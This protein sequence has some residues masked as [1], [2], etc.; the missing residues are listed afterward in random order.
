MSASIPSNINI[1]GNFSSAGFEGLGNF[2]GGLQGQEMPKWLTDHLGKYGLSIGEDGMVKFDSSVTKN[3]LGEA[4]STLLDDLSAKFADDGKGG[5]FDL[6]ELLNSGDFSKMLEAYQAG[7]WASLGGSGFSFGNS[8]LPGE[9]QNLSVPTEATGRPEGDTRSA[10]EIIAANPA[11]ANLGDQ[12]DIKRDQLK[13]RFG[14]WTA[15]NPDPEARAD[16]AYNAA[17][18]LNWIDSSNNREGGY[19]GPGDG[20][21]QGITS[22]GDARHGT[23]AGNLKDFAE[24]GYGA[25]K[26]DHRLDQTN[27]KHVRLDGSN[28]DN[29]EKFMD[30]VGQALGPLLQMF[31]FIPGMQIASGALGAFGSDGMFSTS[32][33]GTS[34]QNMPIRF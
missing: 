4:G 5:G 23:E 6:K 22:S 28:K 32:K 13:E 3:S 34:Y 11:L 9:Q 25:L 31:S 15:D 30:D 1:P 7:D 21:I 26:A 24:Q 29:F 8:D 16:A 27:D 19:R 17:K 14:D 18:V 12:K 2:S 33:R 10:E 20:D